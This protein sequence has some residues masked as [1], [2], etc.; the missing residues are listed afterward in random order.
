MTDKKDDELEDLEDED[1]EFSDEALEEEFDFDSEDLELPID[2]PLVHVEESVLE[3]EEPPKRVQKSSSGSGKFISTL[4]VTAIIGI[5]GYKAY[6]LFLKKDSPKVAIQNTSP[7]ISSE[8]TPQSRAPLNTPITS[9]PISEPTTAQ[10]ND[11][12]ALPKSDTSSSSSALDDLLPDVDSVA[13]NTIEQSSVEQFQVKKPEKENWFDNQLDSMTK[14]SENNSTS[15]QPIVQGIDKQ[16]LNNLEKKLSQENKKQSDRLDNIE[17]DMGKIMQRV[18]D[19]N[20]N[21][22]NIQ[23]NM[24]QISTS[25]DKM[26][27]EVSNLSQIREKQAQRVRANR[28]KQNNEQQKQQNSTPSMTVHAIIPGRAWLR[29]EDGQI[30]SVTDGDSVGRYGKVLRIDA[31]DGVVVTSSGVTLR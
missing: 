14:P 19:L 12:P 30:T 28:T 24:A 16:E 4:V 5:I 17:A 23:N 6:D 8:A 7:K 18:S 2:E 31:N 22:S 29:S 15:Q 25:M 13:N 11:F 27:G 20:K 1:N 10:S 26:S 3:D 21:M 9:K